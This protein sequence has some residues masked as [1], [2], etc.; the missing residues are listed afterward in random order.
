MIRTLLAAAG[1]LVRR[2]SE[3]QFQTVLE[4]ALGAADPVRLCA[5]AIERSL[6]MSDASARLGGSPRF[7]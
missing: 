4:R 2:R 7:E 3:Q 5:A 6:R 1:K